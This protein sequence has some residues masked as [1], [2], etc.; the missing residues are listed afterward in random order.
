[1]ILDNLGVGFT[2]D[3]NETFTVGQTTSST[4]AI[5]YTDSVYAN[6][7]TLLYNVAYTPHEYYA[8]EG[9]YADGSAIDSI[10]ISVSGSTIGDLFDRV[11]RAFGVKGTITNGV[12][13]WDSPNG[14]YLQDRAGNLGNI[15]TLDSTTTTAGNAA[16]STLKVTYTQTSFVERTTKL[17]DLGVN[18]LTS[19][20]TSKTEAQAIAQGY[21]C[22]HNATELSTA[23]SNSSSSAKV[24]LMN[25][26]DM[27]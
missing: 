18:Y 6:R 24:M 15:I 26:I 1:M 19:A 20:V 13:T 21:T 22:V 17:S 25:D 14:V 10:T 12:I 9:C 16:S 8:V 4:L 5:T 23:L 2:T 11:E 3:R 7:D 27:S